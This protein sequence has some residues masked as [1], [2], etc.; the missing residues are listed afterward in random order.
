MASRTAIQRIRRATQN[1]HIYPTIVSANPE[2]IGEAPPPEVVFWEIVPVDV[3]SDRGDEPSAD[4]SP[5]QGRGVGGRG[6]RFSD[7][8]AYRYPLA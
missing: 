5:G 7:D 1:E 3:Y 4:E 8:D 2:V 6:M